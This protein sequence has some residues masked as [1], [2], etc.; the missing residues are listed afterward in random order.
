[1]PLV[2]VVIPCYAQ[3]HYLGEA[4]ESVLAQTHSPYEI[5]VI[6]DGSPDNVRDVVARYPGVRCC[7]QENRGL[8]QA[9][10][11]GLAECSGV[12]VVCL[13]ADD[14]LLPN[15]LEAG[16]Q[17][18]ASRPECG[19]VWGYRCLIDGQGNPIPA[20]LQTFEGPARYDL[21]LRQNVVGPPVVVMFRRA[22]LAELGG[23]SAEQH[24]SEDYEMYLRVAQRY[25]TWC[26]QALIAEYRLH[27]ANMSLNHRGM[28]AGN[29]LALRRQE[30]FVGS[31]AALRRALREGRRLAWDREDCGPRLEVLSQHVRARR[32]IKACQSATALL[33]KYP[34]R[35]LPIVFRRMKRAIFP[36]R[37]RAQLSRR[38][39]PE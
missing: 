20:D 14:R 31:N 36:S 29:L 15:A 24:H 12:F 37:S 34:G 9:R 35:F 4:I 33:Y 10:N 21:L 30:S 8:S 23:F 11:R 25:D 28:L 1:M 6:D 32:W 13:D 26:H 39:T 3:A 18:F 7:T 5:I 38:A 2:S 27:S 19:F 16:V 22:M 17:A